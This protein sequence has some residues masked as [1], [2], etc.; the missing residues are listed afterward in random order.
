VAQHLND[1]FNVR[2]DGII[3]DPISKIFLENCNENFEQRS[4]VTFVGRLVRC[5]NAHK[6]LPAI[7]DLLSEFPDLRCRIVGDGP[8]RSALEKSVEGFDRI[9]FVGTQ[10][11]S[12]VRQ[13]LRRSRVF[14]SGAANEG[15]GITYLEA[16]S[17]GC[18]VVMPA[19]GGGLEIA[20]AHIGTGVHLMPISLERGAVLSALREALHSKAAPFQIQEHT[21]AAV[22]AAYLHLD[23]GFS[24]ERAFSSERVK[25]ESPHV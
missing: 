7:C 17:Q 12:F 3:R 10:G 6:L 15:L 19:S 25:A 4:Y 8:Q 21:P 22:A 1:V 16:L 18:T 9:E 13:Q 20:L 5:K 24:T 2:I 11:R 14:V 23:R